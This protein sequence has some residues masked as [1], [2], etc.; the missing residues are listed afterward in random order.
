MANGQKGLSVLRET[1]LGGGMRD[2][3]NYGE[4]RRS[5]KWNG[6]SG[7]GLAHSK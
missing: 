2:W 6:M 1:C 5:G 7:D 3:G 4:V